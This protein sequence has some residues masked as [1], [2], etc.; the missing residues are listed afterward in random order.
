MNSREL[1]KIRLLKTKRK[2]KMTNPRLRNPS[3]KNTEKKIRD[4]E[5][6]KSPEHGT[7]RSVKNFSEVS[8]LGQNW[9]PR[10]SSVFL[11]PVGETELPTPKCVRRPSNFVRQDRIQKTWPYGPLPLSPRIA[12]KPACPLAA[13]TRTPRTRPP[14]VFIYRHSDEGRSGGIHQRTLS[15]H[16]Q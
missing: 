10:F 15:L 7:S 2:E 16:G 6:Q 1:S 3:A 4:S 5:T 11:M 14:N 12:S 8:R 9:D 13:N